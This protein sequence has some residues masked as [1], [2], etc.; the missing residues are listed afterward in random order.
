MY[1]Y[2]TPKFS[3]MDF[4]KLAEGQKVEFTI[5]EGEKG[6]QAREVIEL[7]ENA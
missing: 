5:A 4:R 3:L 2:I 1:L 7:Q 6:L